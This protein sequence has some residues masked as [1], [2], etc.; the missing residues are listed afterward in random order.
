MTALVFGGSACGKSGYGERLARTLCTRGALLYLATMEPFGHEAEERIEKH[1]RQR[2]GMGFRTVEWFRDLEH[3]PIPEGSTMLLEDLGNWTA[4]EVFASDS[5]EPAEKRM[6]RAL[7]H[8]QARTE[9][10]V[11]IGNDLF[12]DGQVYPR[13]TELYLET[14][15]R[16]QG[17][18]ARRSDTVVE[19][20]CGLPVIWK[21]EGL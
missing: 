10:L 6:V 14:L 11:V 20:V 7:D 12:R 8:L 15:A 18:L 5:R 3:C 21:G 2:A 19:L 4:N 16:V 13:E 1:R 17:E 9:H